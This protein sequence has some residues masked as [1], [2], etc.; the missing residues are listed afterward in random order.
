M[1]LTFSQVVDALAHSTEKY[2]RGGVDQNSNSSPKLTVLC[3]FKSSGA[4]G[5]WMDGR[6]DRQ[7]GM[8]PGG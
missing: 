8:Q 7:D 5:G 2:Y 6:T 4:S 1:V 3:L